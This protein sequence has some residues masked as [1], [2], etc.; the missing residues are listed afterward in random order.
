MTDYE[1]FLPNIMIA[2]PGAVEAVALSYI[3]SAAIRFCNES[4]IW[5]VDI[6][7]LDSAIDED[8]Y[9]VQ[10]S[11]S[12][13][14]NARVILPLWVAYD[15]NEIA[16]KTAEWLNRFDAGWRDKDSG[17]PMYYIV[18]SPGTIRFNRKSDEVIT[19]A[20]E[21]KVAMK[22]TQAATSVGEIVYEDWRD[23]I[24]AGALGMLLNMKTKDWYDERAA[25]GYMK[26]FVNQIQSAKA[27]ARMGH[28]KSATTL[29][30]PSW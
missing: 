7:A 16:E 18:E 4:L 29:T 13:Y 15:G 3:S 14:D 10:P 17:T 5:Q 23:A 1:D 8:T 28:T 20:V 2:V 12:T 21:A 9:S 26:D 30:I 22:P 24:E 27:R 19:G 25:K 6:T 11:D